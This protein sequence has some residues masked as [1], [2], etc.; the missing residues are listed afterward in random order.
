MPIA[1]VNDL[2]IHYQD[3]G[4]GAPVVMIHGLLLGN[5][6][7]WYLTVAPAVARSHRVLLYDLRGHGLSE[8]SP[9]G[10]DLATMSAD[11]GALCR[12][13]L[14][15]PVALVGHSWGALVALRFAMDHADLV[16]RLA[17]IEAPLPPSRAEDFARAAENPL[18]LLEV[19]P[20][21]LRRQWSRPGRR[22]SRLLDTIRGLVEETSL[23]RDVA[24]ERDFADAELAGLACPVLCV[25]GNE[26]A[27]RPAAD[28]LSSTIPGARLVTLPGGHWL[29]F[30]A[31][32]ALARCLVEFLDE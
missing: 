10:Y 25:Y 17:L 15:S 12:R 18:R 22:R 7:T 21:G 5:L 11:L 14:P 32:D 6:A 23:T 1:R 27:C 13:F 20:E 24:A 31:P 29:P 28:R 19:L 26:S 16:S 30:D 8:R 9:G 4:E 2:T 3:F